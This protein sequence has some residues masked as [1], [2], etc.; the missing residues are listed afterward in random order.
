MDAQERRS[1]TDL[2]SAYEALLMALERRQEVLDAVW[3]SSTTD[4]ARLRLSALLGVEERHAQIILD[5]QVLHLTAR[6]RERATE[7]A[8]QLRD[9]LDRDAPPA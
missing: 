4:E 9:Q 7:F 1:T 6:G 3:E 2:L 5:M 8:E